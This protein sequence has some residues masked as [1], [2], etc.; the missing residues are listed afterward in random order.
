M[1]STKEIKT[2]EK[3]GQFF[4]KMML[5]KRERNKEVCRK[6]KNGEIKVAE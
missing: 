3:V 6:I 1:K 2:S 5:E 4:Y